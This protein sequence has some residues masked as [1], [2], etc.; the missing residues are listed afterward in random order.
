MSAPADQL[1]RALWRDDRQT[2]GEWMAWWSVRE[3]HWTPERRRE[4]ALARWKLET[5]QELGFP[6]WPAYLEHLEEER[7]KAETP[8]NFDQPPPEVTTRDPRPEDAP[9]DPPAIARLVKA[10]HESW[11][12]RVG[13][14]RGYRKAGRG[15]VGT[16][17]DA[18][19]ELTHIVLLEARPAALESRAWVSVAYAAPAVEPLRW[20]HD[21]SMVPGKWK[22]TAAEAKEALVQDAAVTVAAVSD[23]RQPVAPATDMFAA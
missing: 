4:E 12:V 10:A 6:S 3:E 19:W 20:K 22:A 11:E 18:R 21:G 9:A 7:V 16:G 1:Q 17:S 5:A 13:Y 14:C 15:N 2:A 23:T 8:G